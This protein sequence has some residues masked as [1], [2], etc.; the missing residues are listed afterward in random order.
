MPNQVDGNIKE[1]RSKK[2]I[3]LSNKNQKEYNN[4]YIGK[5]VEVLFEF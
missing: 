5:N 1:Q 2:L 4:N 3:E